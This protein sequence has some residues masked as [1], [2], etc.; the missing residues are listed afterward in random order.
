MVSSIS[1]SSI[2]SVSFLLSAPRARKPAT[3]ATIAEKIN[4]K[5][6]SKVKFYYINQENQNG[7]GDA[8]LHAESIVGKNPFAVMLPDDLFFSERNVSG[9]NDIQ[10]LNSSFDIQFRKQIMISVL[11]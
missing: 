4:N 2:E 1:S 3:A 6:F 5:I 11:Y 10:F 9:K 8:I 7:L